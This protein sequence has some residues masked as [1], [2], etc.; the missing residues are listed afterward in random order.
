MSKNFVH[1]CAFSAFS[2]FLIFILVAETRFLSNS[3]VNLFLCNQALI[4][5]LED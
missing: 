5:H 1:L 4:V 2:V 3:L